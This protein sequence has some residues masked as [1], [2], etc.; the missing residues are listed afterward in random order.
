MDCLIQLIENLFFF[1]TIL[2]KEDH[3]IRLQLMN[4]IVLY[5]LKEIFWINAEIKQENLINPNFLN[6]TIY[7][8]AL[9]GYENIVKKLP[10]ALKSITR[11]YNPRL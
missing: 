10:A 11:R 5:G 7:K 2:K 8:L 4:R 1:T 3:K 9:Q 6:N